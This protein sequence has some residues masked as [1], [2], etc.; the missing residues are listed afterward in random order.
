[1]VYED[2]TPVPPPPSDLQ[3]W[4]TVYSNDRL[5]PFLIVGKRGSEP[6]PLEK[7][8]FIARVLS[9]EELKT[10]QLMHVLS[11]IR[12]SCQVEIDAQSSQIQLDVE[13]LEDKVLKRIFKYLKKVGVQE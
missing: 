8:L 6:L 13:Q 4:G 5:I 12:G 10:P 3:P 7:K 2:G 9:N 11:L 1:M